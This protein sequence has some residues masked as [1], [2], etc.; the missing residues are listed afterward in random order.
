MNLIYKISHS[1]FS[2]D[3]DHR[4]AKSLK[5]VK[6]ADMLVASINQRLFEID[7]QLKS[8]TVKYS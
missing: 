5:N 6:E 7:K 3:T 8:N 4:F 1:L 2:K